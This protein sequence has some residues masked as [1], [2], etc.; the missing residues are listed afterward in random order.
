MTRKEQTHAALGY[1]ALAEGAAERA[2][3]VTI[4]RLRR[5]FPDLNESD[6]LAMAMQHPAVKQ[7]CRYHMR[8]AYAWRRRLKSLEA[9]SR[10]G[11]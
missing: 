2:P 6:L 5:C 7:E 9:C 10:A 4:N 3:Q 1:A 11:V 8:R